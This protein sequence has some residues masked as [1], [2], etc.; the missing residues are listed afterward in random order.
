MMK[1][2]VLFIDDDE[3][4]IDSARSAITGI[5]NTFCDSCDFSGRDKKL[6]EFNPHVVVLDWIEGTVADEAP[7]AA[8]LAL[9]DIWQ[10]HFCPL[11]VYSAYSK[12]DIG[13]EIDHPFV[14]FVQKGAGS[15]E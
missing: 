15:D 10:N 12:D 4:S 3:Q 7:T 5:G 9:E 1:V 6:I 14:K 8:K 2:R 13:F 11:I